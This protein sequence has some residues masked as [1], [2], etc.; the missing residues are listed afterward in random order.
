MFIHRKRCWRKK[1][2]KNNSHKTTAV[3]GITNVIL[4]GLYICMKV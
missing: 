1:Y 2:Y 4:I 3:N